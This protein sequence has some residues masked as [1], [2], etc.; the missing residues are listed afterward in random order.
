MG[1]NLSL[2]FEVEQVGE[3][4]RRTMETGRENASKKALKFEQVKRQ[5]FFH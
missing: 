1:W 3:N 2:E 4:R 5:I